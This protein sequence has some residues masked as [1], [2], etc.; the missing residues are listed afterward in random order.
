MAESLLEIVVIL[1]G[2]G[3]LIR[4]IRSVGRQGELGSVRDVVGS[5]YTL[6]TRN[7]IDRGR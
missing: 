3:L 5:R 6:P 1:V 7:E 4:A 2:F